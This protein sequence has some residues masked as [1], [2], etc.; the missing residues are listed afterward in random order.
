MGSKTEKMGNTN[1]YAYMCDPHCEK[2]PYS[3]GAEK[4]TY[5]AYAAWTTRKNSRG[6]VIMPQT[7]MSVP[8]FQNVPDLR[9]GV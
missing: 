9:H 5:I 7:V 8:H 6:K 4:V 3:R 2:Q 1:E